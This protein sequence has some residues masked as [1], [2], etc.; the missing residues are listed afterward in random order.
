MSPTDA[1]W[2][3]Q[4]AQQQQATVQ[5][6][7]NSYSLGNLL[8]GGMGDAQVLVQQHNA[9]GA[10]SQANAV[11]S[12]VPIGE[13]CPYIRLDSLITNWCNLAYLF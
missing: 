13:S 12:V 8:N 5:I 11:N 7:G 3:Q 10:V 2:E 4:E 6:Q 1:Y 9:A